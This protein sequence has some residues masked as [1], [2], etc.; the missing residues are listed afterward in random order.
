MYVQRVG[1]VGTCLH[2]V[3]AEA[4][5]CKP[6]DAVGDGWEMSNRIQLRT[7]VARYMIIVR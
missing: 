1:A 4:G 3:S 6:V 7:G 2:E 5:V